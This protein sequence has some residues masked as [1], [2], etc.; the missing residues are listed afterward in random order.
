[1]GYHRAGFDVV[2]VDLKPQPRY[3]FEF[4][5]G[6]ALEYVARH[7]L[8]FDAI[9]ASPPCQAHTALNHARKKQTV[10][11]VQPT[12]AVLSLL[13]VPYVIE[14]V[15][16]APLRNPV[17]LCGTMFDLEVLRH[18][19]FESS[20]PLSPPGPSDHRGTVADGTYVSVHGGGQRS[21]HTI[22]YSAQRPRW[23]RAMGIDWMRT[24][25]EL[26]QAIPPAY[27]QFIG[28]RLIEVLV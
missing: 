21:T 20:I 12:R 9:H 23:E 24:R 7:G 5:R 16:G 22:S 6:D 3:P 27:T 2:G 25:D 18:R 4:H 10:S 8:E 15:P 26:C 1:M 28:E 14:N 19:I 17:V 11:L 13:G